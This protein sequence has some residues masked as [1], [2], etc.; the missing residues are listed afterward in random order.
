MTAARAKSRTGPRRVALDTLDAALGRRPKPADE[1]LVGHPAFEDLDR[2]DRAFARLLV[3]TVL[4]RLGELDALARPHLRFE[5]K[6]LRARNILRLG[7]AQLRFLGTPA[8]AAVNETVRLAVGKQAPMVPMLNAVLRRVADA[9]PVELGRRSPRHAGLALRLLGRRLWR[10]GGPRHRHGPPG[11]GAARSSGQGRSR[12]MDRGAGRQAAAGRHASLPG[13]RPRRPASRLR[14]RCLVGAGSGRGPS[15]P[16][17]WATSPDG[18]CWI[19]ARRPAARPCS[20]PQ[21]APG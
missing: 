9:P 16:D 13:R 12:A 19:S 11:R 2:R 3:L 1:A 15:P 6:D 17:C 4:R 8:H 5:P 18:G 10:A 7:T 14:R 20:S 21:P